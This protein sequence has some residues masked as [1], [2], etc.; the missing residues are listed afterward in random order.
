VKALGVE[1]VE[2]FIRSKREF[3]FDALTGALTDES[4]LTER[5]MYLKMF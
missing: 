4:I 5:E 1:F 2:S 3:E